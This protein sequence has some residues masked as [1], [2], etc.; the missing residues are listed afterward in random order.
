MKLK[1][2][3]VL[4]YSQMK[5]VLE[6]DTILKHL[7]PC[8]KFKDKE[9]DIMQQPYSTIKYI[10]K[11]FRKNNLTFDDI[12]E[13]FITL[14]EIT[15]DDFYNVGVVEFYKCNAYIKQE[16]ELIAKNENILNQSA[17]FDLNKWKVS[18]G[19]RLNA[20][21]I[22]GLQSISERYGLYPFDLA[23]KP[24]SEIFYLQSML[25][26]YDEVNFNY[27]KND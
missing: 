16:F 26:V 17:K 9:I 27:N 5:N 12:C 18:G 14:Y 21:D 23:N 4:E 19:D 10:Q 6:Y 11:I 24:Y 2:I 7:K 8:N 22:I 1:N 13:I 15:K 3:S 20:F 25:K